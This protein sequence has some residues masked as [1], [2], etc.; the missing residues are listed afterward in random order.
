MSGFD[1]NLLK[2]DMQ[3]T[4]KRLKLKDKSTNLLQDQNVKANK[5]NKCTKTKPLKP[6]LSVPTKKTSKENKAFEHA[7]NTKRKSQYVRRPVGYTWN[8]YM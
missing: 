5:L 1:S 4:A 2:L 3:I 7:G 8:R 6:G